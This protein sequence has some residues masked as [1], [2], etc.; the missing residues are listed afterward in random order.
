MVLSAGLANPSFPPHA[1]PQTLPANASHAGQ[2]PTGRMI[3]NGGS[4]WL[5]LVVGA[6]PS[7]VPIKQILVW[8]SE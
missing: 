5:G 4:Q 8:M 7:F 2:A 6:T 3:N 1:R